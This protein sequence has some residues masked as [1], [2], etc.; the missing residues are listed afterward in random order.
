MK[1]SPST[2]RREYKAAYKLVRL[3]C[4]LPKEDQI[5]G[6]TNDIEDCAL[7]SYDYHDSHF[8]GW[9]NRQRLAKFANA[10]LLNRNSAWGIPF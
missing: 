7:L 2:A 1:Q 6:E 4:G 9:I 5:L 8:L 3:Y 10:M